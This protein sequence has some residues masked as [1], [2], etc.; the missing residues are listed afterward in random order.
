MAKSKAPKI[1]DETP[2]AYAAAKARARALHESPD[3]LVGA[4]YDERRDVFTFCLRDQTLLSI[5][6]ASIAVAPLMRAKPSQ[7]HRIE[8]DELGTHV[9]FPDV[10]EG[11]NPVGIVAR[12]FNAVLQAERG[13]SGGSVRSAAKK[14]AAKANG[15]KGGRPR[16]LPA[17]G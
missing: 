13:K 2:A 11:F 5:P 8:I 1:I 9:W 3:A 16:K 10:G 15:K 6:R 7:L 14:R 17:R 4:K 12:R